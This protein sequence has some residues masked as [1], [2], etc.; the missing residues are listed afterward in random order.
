MSRRSRRAARALRNHSLEVIEARA[1]VST[2][3]PGAMMIGEG[4]GAPGRRPAEVRPTARNTRFADRLLVSA[5]WPDLAHWSI[6]PAVG[7]AA[8][9]ASPSIA[10]PATPDPGLISL[11]TPDP[12][13]GGPMIVTPQPSPADRPTGSP[14]AR[15]IRSHTG[16]TPHRGRTAP[17]V[18]EL[19]R[20]AK[21]VSGHRN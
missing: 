19:P 6:P 5:H 13:V 18:P 10:L 16:E 14:V 1:A 8:V 21:T 2:L 15:R 11:G 7:L 20:R 17:R 9:Q 12:R 4:P 3:A